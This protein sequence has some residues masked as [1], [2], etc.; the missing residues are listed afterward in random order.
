MGASSARAKPAAA[1][2]ASSDRPSTAQNPDL[3]RPLPPYRR[4]RPC[5]LV[6]DAP[7][8][9]ECLYH[10]IT[11]ATPHMMRIPARLTSA[12]SAAPPETSAS[13]KCPAKARKTP[14]QNISSECWPHRINGRSQG[15]FSPGQSLGRKR[16]V[17]AAKRQKMG[18]AQHVQIGLV[19]RIHPLFE[20][21]RH[22]RA[23]LRHVPGQR[24]E[25]CRRTDRRCK[26]TASPATTG[27][28]TSARRRRARTRRR[29]RTATARRTD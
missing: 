20:P 5:A 13:T 10:E 7:L 6:F 28:A 4:C 2:P 29:T 25:E 16:T 21:L 3:M 19:D 18:K 14:R 24:D 11:H 22:Q 26:S 12:C 9:A 8:S 27:S 23:E 15:D 1:R 17:S